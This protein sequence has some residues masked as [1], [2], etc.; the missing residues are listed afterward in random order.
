MAGTNQGVQS[1]LQMAQAAQ[2]AAKGDTFSEIGSFGAGAL[3]IGAA[4]ATI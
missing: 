2:V 3:Q 1:Y 4:I